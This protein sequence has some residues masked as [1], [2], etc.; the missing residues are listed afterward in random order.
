MPPRRFISPFCSFL[1][2]FIF[3]LLFAFLPLF[4]LLDIFLCL[5]ILKMHIFLSFTLQSGCQDYGGSVRCCVSKFLGYIFYSHFLVH[6]QV[7]FVRK[8]FL[9]FFLCS[10]VEG[11]QSNV[12]C[13]IRYH[14]ARANA[15]RT[16][17]PA[18]T[19]AP[20]TLAPARANAPRTHAEWQ[21]KWRQRYDYLLHRHEE[22][23][24]R[25]CFCVC[26]L[27]YKQMI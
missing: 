5:F 20:R 23:C 21:K 12:A 2:V 11:A 7:C 22:S 18:R 24:A 19:N 8:K 10:V 14:I 3:C 27:K 13:H 16:L 9:I 25:I 17:A 26:S 1:I 4:Y 6:F 15:P